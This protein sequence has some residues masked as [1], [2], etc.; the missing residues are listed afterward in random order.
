MKRKAQSTNAKENHRQ[1]V[2]NGRKK[3]RF[4]R[5]SIHLT[6][7][8]HI[9]HEEL[10]QKF[11]NLGGGYLW[12]S[13]VHEHGKTGRDGV[14]S[15][16][17]EDDRPQRGERT[18]VFG[19]GNEEKLGELQAIPFSPLS[20]SSP[21]SEPKT[22]RQGVS[23]PASGGGVST[24]RLTSAERATGTAYESKES[25]SED[26]GDDSGEDSDLEPRPK[27]NRPRRPIIEDSEDQGEKAPSTE[28]V[29]GQKDSGDARGYAHTHFACKWKRRIDTS[30]ERF[31]DYQGIHPN[32]KW[33]EGPV[34]EQ[35][36]WEYHAKDGEP[37]R[38]PNG[39]THGSSSIQQIYDA[40]TLGDAIAI[41][42]V[43]IK[44]VSDLV[45]IRNDVPKQAAYQHAHPN[46]RWIFSAPDSFR[47]IFI[48]GPTGTGKTQWALHQ[49]ERPLLV[50]S[51]DQLKNYRPDLYDGIVLDDVKLSTL[52]RE[53]GIM[54]TEWDEEARIRCRYHDAVIP[55]HT[56]KIICA[57]FP[58]TQTFP[59]DPS[60]A[61]R[62]RVTTVVHAP[63]RLWYADND[64]HEEWKLPDAIC[65][66]AQDYV[67]V[68]LGP[69]Q[70][71]APPAGLEL[72][73]GDNGMPNLEKIELGDIAVGAL[74]MDQFF[75]CGAWDV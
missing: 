29:Q 40:P 56:R 59:P 22:P 50:R 38:S 36:I 7:K 2:A 39:P 6:Y 53:Q 21:R 15:L 45:L 18:G 75:E 4:N 54:L 37:T 26:W 62:R 14:L 1:I 61:I 25:D 74:D 34:H 27:S 9:P 44:S 19:G 72:L 67:D 48:W 73:S 66:E 20:V 8:G 24:P 35:R 68:A 31:F 43:E 60:G 46:A 57:N 71:L 32:V 63:G 49:F 12:Y 5:Q 23:T 42:G 3:F 30:N 16:F 52:D 28:E 55:K 13:V 70:W 65:E 41:A 47:I 69:D 51:M 58:F 17:P 33:I 64:Q 10:I 11:A